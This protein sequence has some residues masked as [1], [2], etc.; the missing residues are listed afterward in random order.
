MPDS[1]TN[2]V[3]STQPASF[4]DEKGLLKDG[5]L[6]AYVPEDIRGDKMFGGFK[7]VGDMAKSLAHAERSLRRAGKA[8]PEDTAPAS[9]WDVFYK[10]V[11]RPDNPDDYKYTKPDDIYIMDLTPENMKNLFSTFHKAGLNQKQATIVLDSFI[12]NL[13]TGQKEIESQES[14]EFEEAERLIQ[15]EEGTG[16]DACTHLCNRLISENTK[17]WPADRKE[18]LLEM[19]NDNSVRPY[20]RSFLFNIARKFME[21]KVIPE[22]EFAEARTPKQVEAEISELN[23]TPGFILPDKNGLQLKDT[24]RE[25]YKRLVDKLTR[26]QDELRSMKKVSA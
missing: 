22:Y 24:N 3:D 17:D 18:K 2:E 7:S 15:Q 21:H 4:V 1:A 19:L 20:V 5:W 10:S 23:N 9:E 11:G 12:E 13:R 26:L 25:E 8:M 14:A 16:I 6:N